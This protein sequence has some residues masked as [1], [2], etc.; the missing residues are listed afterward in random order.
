[1]KKIFKSRLFFFILGVLVAVTGTVFAYTYVATDVGFTP[2]D[3]NWTANNA[4]KALDDLYEKIKDKKLL[5]LYG[6]ST[7]SNPTTSS[8][9][10]DPNYYNTDYL[11]YNTSTKVYTARRNFKMTAYFSHGWHNGVTGGKMGIKVNGT[12]SLR[13]FESRDVQT[14]TWNIKTG[15]QIQFVHRVDYSTSKSLFIVLGVVGIDT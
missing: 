14:I 7:T 2:T 6:D 15:D 10:P 4:K 5:V 8:A 12:E 9:I 3:S 1:M 13:H 11:T